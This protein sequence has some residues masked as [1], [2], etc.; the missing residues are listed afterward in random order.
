MNFEILEFWKKCELGK[1]VNSRKIE[2]FEKKKMLF[3]KKNE[4][5][6]EKMRISK[7]VSKWDFF[8]WFS[9][10]DDESIVRKSFF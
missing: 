10:I 9:N 2:S 6:G 7:N 8:D 4:N 3:L 1:N 5:F